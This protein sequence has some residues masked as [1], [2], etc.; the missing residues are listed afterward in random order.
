[1]TRRPPIDMRR[2]LRVLMTLD[3]V[4]GV[5]RFGIDLARALKPLHVDTTF[6]ILGPAPSPAQQRE[7]EAVGPTLHM[8]LPLDWMVGEAS[9]LSGVAEAIEHVAKHNGVDLLHLNVPTQAVGLKTELP[10]VVM[11]HSCIPTWFA[12]VRGS[13]PPSGWDWHLG[14]N[15][16]GFAR[17]DAVLAPSRS[18]ARLLEATYG[19][20]P[21]LDVVY[22]ACP[23]SEPL[24]TGPA[25]ENEPTGAVAMARWWDEAKNGAALDRAAASLNEP[26]TMIGSSEGPNGERLVISAANHVGALSHAEALQRLRAARLFVSPSLYEPFGLAALEAASLGLPLVLADIP[27]YREL[28]ADAALFVEPSNGEAYAAALNGLFSNRD[29]CRALA[30]RARKRAAEFTL[31]RQGSAMRAVYDAVTA[32]SLQLQTG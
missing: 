19:A 27:T 3:A 9:D 32:S 21:H 26:L 10:I 12:G 15:R 30:D 25:T 24:P 13:Q 11:S 2:P 28:W 7:I 17:A 6:L 8:P 14:L 23:G 18:H 5:W 4:G 22:N 20:I 1:M 29:R 16:D 31:S